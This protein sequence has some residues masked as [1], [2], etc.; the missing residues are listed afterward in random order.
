MTNKTTTCRSKT[1][2]ALSSLRAER[3]AKKTADL[4]TL[5]KQNVDR[6]YSQDVT[7]DEF[8]R[9]NGVIWRMVDSS[10]LRDEVA[11]ILRASH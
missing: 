7:I 10:G 5:L 3:K 1:S 8:R 9:V 11:A 2:S 6:L 4:V